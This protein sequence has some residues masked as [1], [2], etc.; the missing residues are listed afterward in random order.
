MKILQKSSTG[1]KDLLLI[2]CTYSLQQNYPNPFNPYT[3][4]NFTL[5][6]SSFVELSISDITGQQVR[7]LINEEKR[8]GKYS[9]IWD[10]RDDSGRPASSGVYFYRI[11]AN[12]FS[13]VKKMILLR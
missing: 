3:V 5:P 12:N 10:T 7:S 9:V 6:F 1:I 11:R 13:M 8:S 4:L 2:P